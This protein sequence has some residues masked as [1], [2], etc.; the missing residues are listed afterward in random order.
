MKIMFVL[1][2]FSL[3]ACSMR[4]NGPQLDPPLDPTEPASE[5]PEKL[6]PIE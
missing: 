6:K 2:A 5:A 1:C 3:F 4:C